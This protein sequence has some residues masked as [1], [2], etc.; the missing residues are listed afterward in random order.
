[1]SKYDMNH[2]S[3]KER[4]GENWLDEKVVW[5]LTRDHLVWAIMI[6]GITLLYLSL[7]WNFVFGLRY[8]S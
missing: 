2:V 1:M 8:G 3:T 6:V 4:T 5:F 7:D